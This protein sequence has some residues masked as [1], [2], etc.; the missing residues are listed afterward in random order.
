MDTALPPTHFELSD[1]EILVK[2]KEWARG[3]EEC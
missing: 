2:I 3:G 1:P